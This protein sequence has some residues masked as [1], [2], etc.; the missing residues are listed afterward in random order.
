MT[1]IIRH[2][3]MGKGSSAF[4]ENAS[5]AS[6]SA[7]GYHAQQIGGFVLRYGLVAILLYFGT[8]KFT[9]R[10][11]GRYRASSWAQ[12]LLPLAASSAGNARRLECDRRHRNLNRAADWRSSVVGVGVDNRKSAGGRNIPCHP[13]FSGHNTGRVARNAGLSGARPESGRFFSP[14]R[15][16]PSRRFDLDC[17]R[18]R[19]FGQ[20]PQLTFW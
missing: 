17:R 3:S 4:P 15:L 18:S 2:Q 6:A 14:E 12:S 1:T 5:Y 11:G 10:G 9:A 13:E 19:R 20:R 8:Y 16:F 7:F